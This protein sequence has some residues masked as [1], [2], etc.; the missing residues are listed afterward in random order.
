MLLLLQ[1]SV[2]K[3]FDGLMFTFS[4]GHHSNESTVKRRHRR[5]FTVDGSNDQRLVAV[6]RC[7]G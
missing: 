3:E 5:R 7:I 6:R 4:D 1:L 2:I